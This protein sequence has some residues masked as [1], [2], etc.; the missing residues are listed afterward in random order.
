[1][2]IQIIVMLILESRQ[3]DGVTMLALLKLRAK[4]EEDFAI[5]RMMHAPEDLLCAT[6][7]IM[8]A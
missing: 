6:V 2:L 4:D 1:M 7:P 3:H 8:T 5:W